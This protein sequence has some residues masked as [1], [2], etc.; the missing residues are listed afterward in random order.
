MKLRNVLAGFL[1]S[2]AVTASAGPLSS[3]KGIAPATPESKDCLF[4]SAVGGPVWFQEISFGDSFVFQ[5]DRYRVDLD[6]NF[7]KGYGG[8]LGLGCQLNSGLAF[9]LSVGYYTATADEAD[10]DIKRGGREVVEIRADL[11]DLDIDLTLVPVNFNVMYG[12]SLTDSI[13]SYIGAGVGVTYS[14]LES[15]SVGGGDAWELGA[16][17]LGGFAFKITEN[18]NF[19]LGYRLLY[20]QVEEESLF[21]HALEAGFGLKF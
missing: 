7:E 8:S 2:G 13:Y 1:L 12:F 16:Q 4:I 3:G 5:G 20:T 18:L 11:K 6:L 10:I 21:G 17:G 9:G 19:K 15:D 14:E